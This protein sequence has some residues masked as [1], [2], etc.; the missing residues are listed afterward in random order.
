MNTVTGN[1]PHGSHD[2]GIFTALGFS[3]AGLRAAHDDFAQTSGQL[4]RQL[5]PVH[6]GTLAF[7]QGWF[8][9]IALRGPRPVCVT[10]KYSWT[11]FRQGPSG[12]LIARK[13]EKTDWICDLRFAMRRRHTMSQPFVFTHCFFIFSWKCAHTLTRAGLCSS[14]CNR[15][16]PVCAFRD[17]V[18]AA[19]R[20]LALS[21]IH[22]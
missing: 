20:V 19:I 22:I 9:L 18:R 3:D 13:G 8:S 6:A 16:K 12:A 10:G 5:I 14:K 4:T 1:Y 21:L 11:S 7:E 17:S 2:L 15:C